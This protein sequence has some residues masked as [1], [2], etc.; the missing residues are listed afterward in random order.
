MPL[1][2]K[3]STNLVI[4]KRPIKD[5][6]LDL[7]EQPLLYRNSFDRQEYTGYAGYKKTSWKGWGP[8]MLSK[9]NAVTYFLVY[10]MCWNQVA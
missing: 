7:T 2:S 9:L 10:F 4:W 8:W 3:D 1:D 6:S 5:L